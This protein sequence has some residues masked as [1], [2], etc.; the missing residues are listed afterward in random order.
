MNDAQKMS[1]KSLENN[2]ENASY[3]DTYGWILFKLGKY[4]DARDYIIKSLKVNGNSAVVNDHLGDIY[5]AMGDRTNAMKYWKKAY[6]LA[7]DN[8]EFKNKISK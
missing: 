5:D 6:E 8:L 4:E 1:K 2:P 3:L 7:P